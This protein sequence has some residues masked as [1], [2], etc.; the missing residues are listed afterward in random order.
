MSSTTY[1]FF[2]VS[3]ASFC[4]Q[5]R[6]A[7]KHVRC[8]QNHLSLLNILIHINDLWCLKTLDVGRLYWL[9]EY[10]YCSQSKPTL[11]CDTRFLAFNVVVV[12][13]I[14]SCCCFFIILCASAPLCVYMRARVSCCGKWTEADVVIKHK[15]TPWSKILFV[16]RFQLHTYSFK[17][18]S[19]KHYTKIGSFRNRY[20]HA[21]Q[22][23]SKVCF[24]SAR[25][26]VCDLYV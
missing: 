5:K 15:Y 6:G 3:K 8:L 23:K 22:K 4:K 16:L 10:L 12:L 7:L 25:I 14:F 21:T 9:S 2:S 19:N 20:S 1:R 18:K 26:I 24:Y 11:R 13:I 17:W